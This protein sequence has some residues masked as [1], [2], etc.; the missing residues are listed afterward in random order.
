M[1]L[2][3]SVYL[4][5]LS[6]YSF[7]SI[8]HKFKNPSIIIIRCT[9][10]LR[11]ERLGFDSGQG[12]GYFSSPPQPDWLWRPS[13]VHGEFQWLSSDWSL[14]LTIHFLLVVRLRIRE[15]FTSIPHIITAWSRENSFIHC[16]LRILFTV[17]KRLEREAPSTTVAVTFP[18]VD[19]GRVV[20]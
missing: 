16:L 11:A 2:P 9:Q 15:K 7:A 13:N 12:Q 14:K 6:P 10:Y 19:D 18:N 17:I 4:L 8:G 20:L 1:L 3:R 5:L